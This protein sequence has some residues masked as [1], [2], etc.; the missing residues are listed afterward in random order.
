[1]W[2]RMFH[3]P[4]PP[5]VLRNA[6]LSNKLWGCESLELFSPQLFPCLLSFVKIA[7]LAGGDNERKGEQDHYFCGDQKAVWWAHKENAEGWVRMHPFSSVLGFGYMCDTGQTFPPVANFKLPQCCHSQWRVKQKPLDHEINHQCSSL[8][9]QKKIPSNIQYLQH[10]SL[11]QHRV[12]SCFL[13]FFRS[14]KMQLATVQSCKGILFI[15]KSS[16]VIGPIGNAVRWRLARWMRTNSA[17]CSFY[18]FM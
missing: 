7:P 6:K 11:K 2:M 18:Y 4:S 10:E 15:F 8:N 9:W 16:A 5:S 13:T 14:F 1:M 3:L 17:F 12:G